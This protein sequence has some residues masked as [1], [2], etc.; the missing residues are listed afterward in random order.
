MVHT[1]DHDSA[2]AAINAAPSGGTV[3]F[4]EGEV[5][6]EALTVLKD[7]TL[8]GNGATLQGQL[9]VND[10][11]VTVDG[12]TLTA[13]GEDASSK[14]VALKVSGTKAFTLKNSTV[15][16]KA[17][18]AVNIMT[19]GEITLANNVFDAGEQY[20]YNMIEFSIGTARDI[21]RA[22]VSNNTFTGTLKNNAISF[23][24]LLEGA[25][26]DVIGNTF[27]PAD[28]SNNFMR[29]SNPKS[30]S[31]QFNVKDNVYSYDSDTP[32]A[33]G[34]TA[35]MLLQDYSSDGT[36]DFS[37][38]TVTFDNLRRGDTKITK[39]GEGLDKAFYVYANG[40]GILPAGENDPVAIF[41]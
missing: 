30:V 41:Q 17:R 1:S 26:I 11:E 22:I 32:D 33:S 23:Y 28:V 34:Y 40:K 29:L 6:S 10:A 19:A 2:S 39:N 12:F 38:F 20:V 24:N 35:F 37:K 18:T 14:A 36:Q 21:S 5:V 16:G 8:V 7:L 25:T 3:V 13:A 4:S 15:N 31:A 27:G 9:T